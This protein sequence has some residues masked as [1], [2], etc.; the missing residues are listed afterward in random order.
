[1]NLQFDS[2]KRE[3]LKNIESGVDFSPKGSIDI[4][5]LDLVS[6][7]NSHPN[8][9]TTST[10]SGRI[11]VFYQN[12]TSKSLTENKGV[13]WI[14]V[15]HGIINKVDIQTALS[16]IPR[17]ISDSHESFVFL[18]AEPLIFHVA[19][20]DIESARSLHALVLQAGYRESG[21]TL[22]QKKTMLAIRTTAFL[23]ET[24]IAK[25]SNLLISEELLDIYI[26]QCNSRL[27][28]NFERM[29]N[30]LRAIKS[31]WNFPCLSISNLVDNTSEHDN[32]KLRNLSSR[33]GHVVVLISSAL[34]S[35]S[36]NSAS[37]SSA[38]TSSAST[39]SASTISAASCTKSSLTKIGVF[40]GYGLD[41][42][43]STSKR[44]I[45]DLTLDVKEN[46]LDSFDSS[47]SQYDTMHSCSVNNISC[48]S[49][50]FDDIKF[51]VTSGGRRGP[52]FAL[53]AA[54][55][56]LLSRSNGKFELI[57]HR[58]TGEIP[59]PRWGHTLTLYNK[60]KTLVL[61]GGRNESVIFNDVYS[62]EILVETNEKKDLSSSGS[63]SESKLTAIL[64]WKR[65]DLKRVGDLSTSL[66]ADLP[67]LKPIFFH[68][69]CEVSINKLND[70]HDP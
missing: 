2:F 26:E 48:S 63:N 36:T 34:G 11:S 21:V 38:S 18:K 19:C 25:G 67:D 24:I 49:L 33:W 6:L 58:E 1:M 66:T 5:I 46:N 62:L 27:Q 56:V 12:Y 10:C 13:N 20:R 9:V 40:G 55:E 15:K 44:G 8:Y 59:S 50:G 65:L 3:T 68:A 4:P 22:G 28:N 70:S 23:F 43:G 37:T 61:Y 57:S 7:I 64:S 29:E 53:P 14:V 32:M 41:S 39:S 54:I 35:T 52:Q 30:L 16:E 45:A 69:A 60:N 42:A 17:D 31:D 51:M 47:E